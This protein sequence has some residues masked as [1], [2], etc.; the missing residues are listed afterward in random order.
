VGVDEAGRDDEAG[1]GEVSVGDRSGQVAD[2]RDLAAGDAEVG[3]VRDTAGAVDDGPA[4]KNQLERLVSP[5]SR[6]STGMPDYSNRASL[7]SGHR[8]RT[9][10]DPDAR[11][12]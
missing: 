5:P 7:T 3:D 10:C 8:E 1:G 11:A 9:P 12:P 6:L 2:G 4:P